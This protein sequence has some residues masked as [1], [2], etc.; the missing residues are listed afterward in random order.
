MIVAGL[1]RRLRGLAWYTLSML[2]VLSPV[3]VLV[4][5]AVLFAPILGIR[6]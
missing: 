2:A 3:V 6:E 4:V 1:V 5:L